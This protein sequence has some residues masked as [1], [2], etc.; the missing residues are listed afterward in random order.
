VIRFAA[1]AFVV[2]ALCVLPAHAEQLTSDR[3]IVVQ[4]PHPSHCNELPFGDCMRCATARGYSRAEAR[5][6]CRMMR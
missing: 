1:A 5:P 3:T 2:L 6:Y 4:N